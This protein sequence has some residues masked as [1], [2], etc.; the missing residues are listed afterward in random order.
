[1]LIFKGKAEYLI[2][3]KDYTDLYNSWE[4]EMNLNQECLDDFNCRF[5]ENKKRKSS[6]TDDEIMNEKKATKKTCLSQ[7][8]HKVRGFINRLNLKRGILCNQVPECIIGA[9]DI[10]GELV[11]L[12]KY[13]DLDEYNLVPSSIANRKFPQVVIKFYES[14]YIWN[15]RCN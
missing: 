4:P 14:H 8:N 15:L 5:N 2:K 10:T 3:W 9:T 12:V 7:N 6:D 13:E 11:F 1:L